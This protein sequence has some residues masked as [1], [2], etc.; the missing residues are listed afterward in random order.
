MRR[1][2]GP[3]SFPERARCRCS[4]VQLACVIHQRLLTMVRTLHREARS[5]GGGVWQYWP[6]S[7]FLHYTRS[8]MLPPQVDEAVAIDSG[9]LNRGWRE[10]A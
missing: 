2:V 3:S 5:S 8:Q 10:L 7:C 4:L 9:T 1:A 6:S